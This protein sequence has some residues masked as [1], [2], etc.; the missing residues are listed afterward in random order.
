MISRTL[1]VR[2][3]RDREAVPTSPLAR[4]RAVS[5]ER[6]AGTDWSARPSSDI[7][8]IHVRSSH[9]DVLPLV[10]THGWPGSIIEMLGVV[11]EIQ[12]AFKPLR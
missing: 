8:F 10:I 11:G 2:P 1:R 4:R 3:I 6:R 12:A 5:V 7:H 9:A